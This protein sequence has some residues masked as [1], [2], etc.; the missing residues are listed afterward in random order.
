MPT[1]YLAVTV[2]ALLCL[3]VLLIRPITDCP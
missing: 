2:F 1:L 3:L